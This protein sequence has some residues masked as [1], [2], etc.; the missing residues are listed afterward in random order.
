MTGMERRVALVTGGASGIG[1]ATCLALHEDGFDVAVLDRDGS[2]AASTARRCG[3]A[4][5]LT[6][7]LRDEQAV[8]Q[9]V[10]DVIAWRG[11]LDVV[12]NAAGVLHRTGLADTDAETWARVLDINLTGTFRVCQA[13]QPHLLDGAEDGT[14]RI[15]NI[16]SCAGEVGYAYPAYTASKGGIIA[17]TRQLAAE[18][19]PHRITVNVVN[20][21]FIRTPIN[22][23]AFTDP[24]Q[25]RRVA[26]RI[27]LGRMGRPDEVA[28]V[29]RFLATPAAGYITAETIRVDGGQT[30]IGAVASPKKAAD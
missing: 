19:A 9:A 8:H 23:D 2:G 7:D 12:V 11:R 4:L 28:A 22:D 18:L 10:A 20:P 17:L 30:A 27:P 21:G 15:I 3:D 24:A 6:V 5:P 26:E 25:E 29:V 13:A 1:A 16:G 14:K